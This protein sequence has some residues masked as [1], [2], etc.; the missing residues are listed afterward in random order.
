MREHVDFIR[1]DKAALGKGFE[2]ADGGEYPAHRDSEQR[3]GQFCI[4][5][6]ILTRGSA[7]STL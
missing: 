4:H 5:P 3:L 6:A 1:C 7:E 2:Q